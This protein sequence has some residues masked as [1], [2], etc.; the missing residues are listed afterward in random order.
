MAIIL[1][2]F[3]KKIFSIIAKNTIIQRDFY[4]TGGTAL[5]ECY[6]HHRESVDLDFFSQFPFNRKIV[7]EIVSSLQESGIKISSIH[8]IH[9]R[10]TFDAIGD[11]GMVCKLDFCHYNFPRLEK[12]QKAFDSIVVDSIRDI[13][14]NKWCTLFER[15]EAKDILDIACLVKKWYMST[16]DQSLEK[17]AKDLNKKFSLSVRPPLMKQQYRDRLRSSGADKIRGILYV[18][19]G[20]LD[21]FPEERILF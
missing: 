8:K 13:L 1:N 18:D 10:Y 7:D 11:N 15:N 4:F 12:S 17:I 9:D 3:Q 20:K 2:N 6:L 19:L 5:S 14:T 16:A 21:I